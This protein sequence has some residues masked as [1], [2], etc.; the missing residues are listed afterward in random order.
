[1]ARTTGTSFSRA[2]SI[3]SVGTDAATEITNC[4]SL[5]WARISL[6]TSATTCGFTQRKIM[7]ALFTASALSVPACTFSLSF[8]IR[9]RSGCATVAHVCA[10]DNNPSRKKDC[11]R[12]APIFPAPR[13]ATFLFGNRTLH[14]T[15]SPAEI[16]YR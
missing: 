1:M 10:G 12:I 7:S 15:I 16:V 3:M 5:M 14:H 9:A 13:T 6:A 4:F 11:N 2:R 8:S